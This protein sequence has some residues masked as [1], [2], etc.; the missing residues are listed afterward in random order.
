MIKRIYKAIIYRLS[1]FLCGLLPIQKRKIVISSYYGRGYGDNPKYI[2][3]ELLRFNKNITII[4]LLKNTKEANTL[5]TNVKYSHIGSFKSIYHLATAKIWIDNCRKTFLFKR[6]KQYYLQTWHGFALKRIEKDVKEHLGTG[7]VKNAI[8]DSKYID[9]IVSDSTFMSNV[10]ENSFWYNGEI[11]EWG[12]PRNDILLKSEDEI[13]AKVYEHFDLKQESKIILYA[14]TFRANGALNAYNIDYQG[15]L[16]SCEKRFGHKFVVLVRLHPNIAE[17]C[18]FLNFEQD[19]IINASFYP[20]MQELLAAAEIVISDYSSLMF[21]FAITKKPC[22]QFA[23]DIEEYKNDRNFYFP[24]DSMPFPLCVNNE[25]LQN[26]IFLF[27]EQKY[28]KNLNAFFERVGMVM[29][30]QASKKCTDWIIDK[31]CEK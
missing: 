28:K 16:K 25:E 6:Q 2:V 13:S 22:F 1:W 19:K 10:Y 27:D 9:L 29:D 7:Y 24:V 30:G 23:T 18:T 26:A 4:W 15:L 20:D 12:Q 14:P 8:K 11:V 31:C 3:E 21:D 17:K 5:P